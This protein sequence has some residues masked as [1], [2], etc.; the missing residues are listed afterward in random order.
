MEIRYEILTLVQKDI[1]ELLNKKNDAYCVL[2]LNP[3]YK[4]YN[5]ALM[6]KQTLKKHFAKH[7]EL[8]IKFNYTKEY[9]LKEG[10]KELEKHRTAFMKYMPYGSEQKNILD[11]GFIELQKDL[12]Y[13]QELL[14]KEDDYI[15]YN[16][17]EQELRD[18]QEFESLIF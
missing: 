13:C 14:D 15:N 8:R 4:Q 5:L 18:L 17:L 6:A 2:L 10:K 1:R 9:I 7:E 12:D 16:K 11:I 3:I